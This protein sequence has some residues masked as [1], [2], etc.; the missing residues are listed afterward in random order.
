VK[1]LKITLRHE[2]GSTKL[3][4]P[5]NYQKDLG[6]FNF[7]H[8]G[9]LYYS[10]E[11]GKSMLLLSIAD[12]DWKESMI[13]EYV[14]EITETNAKAISEANETRTEQIVDEVKLRRIELKAKLNQELTQDEVDAIDPE[15]PDSVFKT[16]KIL[17][18]KIKDH[19]IIETKLK[20]KDK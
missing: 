20:A 7:Q 12:K 8:K 18:D 17:A 13:R 5:E 2:P 6:D 4:Y 9:N 10:D 19:K 15:K 3:I 1:Y 11:D 14:E 16:S